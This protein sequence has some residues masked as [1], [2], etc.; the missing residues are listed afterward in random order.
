MAVRSMKKIPV[1]VWIPPTYGALY[2]IEITRSDDSTDDITNIIYEGEVVDGVTDT[3]GNFYFLI[4]NSAETYTGVWTGN[5]VIKIYID[6]AT[7]ATTLRFRGRIEKV[8]YQD[9]KIR[10]NGRSESKKLLDITVT[11]EYTST[12]TSSIITDLFDKYVDF[13]YT[14]VSSETTSVTSTWYQKPMFECIRELCNATG[15]DFYVDSNLDAHYYE[16]GTVNNT[17]EA[18][19]HTSNLFSVGDFAYDQSLIK[20]RIIVYGDKIEDMDI[21][22]TAEDATSQTEYEIKELIINDR[23]IKTEIQA[24][25]RAD[26]ELSLAKDPPLVGD[27]TSIGLA[28]IQPG[29]NIQISAPYSNLSPAYYKILKYRHEFKGFMKTILTIEKE[30]KSVYH[31]LKE[32][33]SAEQK[34]SEMPNPNEMRYSWIDTFDTDT[35]THSTTEVIDSVLKTTNTTGTWISEVKSLSL[36]A[37]DVELRAKGIALAG[38]LYYVSSDNG[39]TWQAISLNTKLILAPPGDNLKIKIDLTSSSTEIESI[40]LLYKT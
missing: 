9:N 24:Q 4:D 25:E 31:I 32:R 35:G 12:G 15:Y 16:S 36:N 37:T 10:I 20:N 3:I 33:I 34:L 7:T 22:A 18:V 28:T 29:E 1:K 27:V 17:N 38:T 13:T 39:N 11:Q 40:N 19:I 26:Y 8:S 5:E 6:Y 30:P 14:N 2:K 21:I 23:N